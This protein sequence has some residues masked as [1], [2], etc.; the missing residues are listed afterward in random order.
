MRNLPAMQDADREAARYHNG[1]K[2]LLTLV[3]AVVTTGLVIILNGQ[4]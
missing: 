3:S 1:V 4:L 2:W